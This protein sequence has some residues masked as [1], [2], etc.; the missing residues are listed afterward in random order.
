MEFLI[1][2]LLIA[3]AL[4]VWSVARSSRASAVAQ[5]AAALQHEAELVRAA[6]D[7]AVEAFSVPSP[8]AALG[9]PPTAAPLEAGVVVAPGAREAAKAAVEAAD[10]AAQQARAAVRFMRELLAKGVPS[11]IDQRE[12]PSRDLGSEA[13]SHAG[14]AAQAALEARRALASGS[15]HP[16]VLC[17][18]AIHTHRAANEVLEAN[19]CASDAVDVGEDRALFLQEKEVYEAA[20]DAALQA[21]SAAISLGAQTLTTELPGSVGA[22]L[23]TIVETYR[24]AAEASAANLATHDASNAAFS[25]VYELKKARTREEIA[26]AS[27]A[28]R[29]AIEEYKRL[30]SLGINAR[31]A[32]EVAANTA[33][34]AAAAA[35]KARDAAERLVALTVEGEAAR[36]AAE[37]AVRTAE[38]LE[39]AAE[40]AESKATDYDFEEREERAARHLTLLESNFKKAHKDAD[41]ADN[42]H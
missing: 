8:E 29:T 41:E 22:I 19:G 32:A 24:A 28:A 20:W 35:Q 30:H 34:A 14:A 17:E 4:G 27:T 40:E 23:A 7:A 5:G 26:N 2:L 21:R 25:A 31:N 6:A 39:D 15:L 18:I 37:A 36:A 11:G 16:R 13:E 38:W 1:V 3:I 10:A 9:A 33:I 42:A 12:D